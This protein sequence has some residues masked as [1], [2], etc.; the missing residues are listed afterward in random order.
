MYKLSLIW[1][2]RLMHELQALIPSS[3]AEQ[4]EKIQHSSKYMYTKTLEMKCVYFSDFLL[5]QWKLQQS[6]C[7][8]FLSSTCFKGNLHTSMFFPQFLQMGTT[9]QISYLLP[10]QTK[11]FQ[12]GSTLK[13]KNLL[14]KEQ[15]HSFKSWPHSKSG[16]NENDK[17]AFP[18]SI[19]VHF[20]L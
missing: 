1:N 18:E 17:A 3:N 10:W 20:E 2:N 4:A 11:L 13:G 9:F 8:F 14:L 15:I 19:S 7:A 6:L 5:K 16:K 12:K